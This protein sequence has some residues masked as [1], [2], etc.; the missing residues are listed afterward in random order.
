VSTSDTTT[1]ILKPHALKRGDKVGLISPA[2]RPDGPAVIERAVKAMEWM[3]FKPVIAQHALDMQG[4]LAGADSD[5]L[6]DLMTFFQDDSIK[7]IFCLSGGYGSLRLLD[8]IDYKLIAEHPKVLVGSDDNTALLLA[9][10]KLT[11]MVVFHG[12]NLDQLNSPVSFENL[13]Q[14][15]GWKKPLKPL[16]VRIGKIAFGGSHY[17]PVKGTVSGRLLGGNLTAIGSLM[18]TP[19]QPDFSE[20][21]LFLEDK[22]ERNDMLDRWF[23]TLYVSGQLDK[24]AGVAFGDF[25]NCGRK[26]SSNMLSLEDLFGDRLKEMNKVSCFGF[27]VGQCEESYSVPIGV[28]TRLNT[29]DGKLEFLESALV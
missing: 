29:S 4:F 21:I 20:S 22:N 27:P 8:K 9:V 24:V 28:T 17:A 23:S 7:G 10:N 16:H 13:Q 11:H 3:G 2:S 25:V 5:R 26:G 18:G 12:P 6:A 14:A 19:Y 1:K 15:V